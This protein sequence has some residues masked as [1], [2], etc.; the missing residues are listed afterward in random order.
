V[1]NS[2]S[3]EFD[4]ERELI[5]KL[6]SEYTDKV[7]V[8]VEEQSK[9]SQNNSLF[10][11][12][13]AILP[14]IALILL[15]YLVNRLDYVEFPTTDTVLSLIISGILIVITLFTAYSYINGR[16]KARTVKDEVTLLT[17]QLDVLVYRASQLEEHSKLDKAH[18]LEF[19]LRLIEA[20]GALNLADRIVVRDK[21]SKANSA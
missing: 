12:A 5:L 16:R 20:Q 14:S 10:L 4:T 9:L 15:T 18:R 6:L 11:L 7:K 21:S 3:D 19:R 1:Q 13:T 17:R 8:E 2:A